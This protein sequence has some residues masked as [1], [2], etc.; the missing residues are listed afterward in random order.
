M[1]LSGANRSLQRLE[2]TFKKLQHENKELAQ[3]LMNTRELCSRVEQNKEDL[4]RQMT[5]KELDYEQL[6]NELIDKRAE[7]DLLK[8][9][10]NSER[11]MVKNLEDLIASN[12]EKDFQMQLSTQERDSEIKLLKDRVLLSEQK[13]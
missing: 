4:M 11:G 10:V 13:M 8:S 9:Q 1:K 2:D 7:N 12:R 3:D 6:N 5:S